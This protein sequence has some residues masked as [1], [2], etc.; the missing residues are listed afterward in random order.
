[1]R[2]T[3]AIF[4]ICAGMG[5]SDC[6]P[7]S[8]SSRL[9]PLRLLDQPGGGFCD[10]AI[11]GFEVRGDGK[12]TQSA[13]WPTVASIQ[14]LRDAFAI[15]IA[16]RESDSGAGRWRWRESRPVRKCARWRNPR[17]W[18]GQEFP[19]RDAANE[20]VPLFH[21][22]FSWSHYNRVLRLLEISGGGGGRGLARRQDY[23][24]RTG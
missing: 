7:W 10:V 22:E 9:S 5:A 4:S 1:M 19:A 23:G 15:G 14:V 2:R 21:F 16:E 3:M 8:M 24:W 18:A 6:Y 20:R 17:R 13:I 11:A 12:L